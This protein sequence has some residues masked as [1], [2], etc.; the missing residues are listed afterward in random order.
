MSLKLLIFIMRY[1]Q[2]G[3]D[4]LP[5]FC[6]PLNTLQVAFTTGYCGTADTYL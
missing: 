2:H 5:V 3:E 1:F 6:Q 4:Y